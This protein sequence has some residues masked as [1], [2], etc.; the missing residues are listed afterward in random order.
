MKAHIH[1]CT[2]PHTKWTLLLLTINTAC[3]PRTLRAAVGQCLIDN[4][5]V[6]RGR[7]VLRREKT[8]HIATCKFFNIF[9]N[10][11]RIKCI[12][13]LFMLQ[14]LNTILCFSVV[15]PY[16]FCMCSRTWAWL[17]VWTHMDSCR[18]K[19]MSQSPRAFLSKE[20][21]ANCLTSQKQHPCQHCI[22]QY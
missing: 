22:V 16:N 1:T 13:C 14:T 17:C 19:F 15:V 12:L 7:V 5:W 3:G 9:L 20:I 8:N 21:L 10:L 11:T 18:W 2:H 6:Y 4:G